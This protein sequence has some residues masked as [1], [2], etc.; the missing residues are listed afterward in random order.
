MAEAQPKPP[1]KKVQK[2][3]TKK[4]V[5]NKVKKP[6]V[7]IAQTLDDV[8]VDTSKPPVKNSGKRK[9][10]GLVKKKAV[11]VKSEAIELTEREERFCRE[12]VCD[13]ALNATRAYR[14]AF[15]HVAYSTAKVNACKLLTQ[16]NFSRRVK[17]LVQD[18]FRR[19]D[20]S[21][22]RVL[23]ELAKMAFYDPRDFYDDDGRIK[24]LSELEPDQAAVIAGIETLHKITGDDSDCMAIVTKIKLPDKRANLELLGRYL[25]LFSDSTP[26][27]SKHI[28]PLL[29]AVLDNKM[30]AREAAYKISILGEP[31]PEILK[32]ELSKAVL[33]EEVPENCPTPDEIEKRAMEARLAAQT[34]RDSWVPQRQAEVILLK[35]EMKQHNSFSGDG[36][37]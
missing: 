16:T 14:K 13:A 2:K 27:P 9:V 10:K 21:I 19:L 29:Q 6:L 22:E 15:P 24:P 33:E 36:S 3:T 30:S 18:R 34:Q 1:K 25:K 20:I 32:I 5:K 37:E 28:A 7:K 35:E 26:A 11:S 8:R 23:A 12:Y 31:L 4:P 17:E